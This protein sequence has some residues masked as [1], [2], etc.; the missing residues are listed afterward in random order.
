[1]A[2]RYN[3]VREYADT[4]AP[5]TVDDVATAPYWVLCAVRLNKPLSYSRDQKRSV[6]KDTSEGAQIRGITI[7]T[8][9][10]LQLQI[11]GS[12]GQHTKQLSATLLQTH[13]NYLI[14]LLPS[15]WLLAWIVHGEEK[16]RDLVERIKKLEPCNKWDDGL[17]FVGR[18]ESV[19]KAMDRNRETGAKSTR[20]SLTAYGFRE[21]DTAIF[22]DPFLRSVD[23]AQVGT[24]MAR[25]GLDIRQLFKNTS[26]Q[27]QQD[28]VHELIPALMEVFIGRGLPKEANTSQN[29]RLQQTTGGGIV[30]GGKPEEA[31]FAYLVPKEVGDLLGKKSRSKKGGIL[32]Y[33]D[34]LEL[35]FG[36]QKYNE[37]ENATDWKAFVPDIDA[38]SD[39]TT[40]SQRYTGVPMMGAFLPLMPNFD[41]RPMWSVLQQ[42]L[43]PVVNEMYTCLRVNE[44]GSVVPTVVLRQI[45]FTTPVL[46]AKLD[47]LAQ[48]GGNGGMPYTGFMDVP[49]WVLHPV[50]I[51]HMDI[52]RS[53][54]TRCNFVHVYGQNADVATNVGMSQ[55]LAQNP[56][57]RDD[58]DIQRSGLHTLMTTVACREVN[59]VGNVPSKWIELIAD[60][61]IGSQYT[62]NGSV[63][64]LGI[65][66]PI[67]EGDNLEFGNAVFHIESVAH[68]CSVETGTGRS[69]WSTTLTL[70]NGLRA[71][72]ARRNDPEVGGGSSSSTADQAGGDK[73]PLYPGLVNDDGT[74]L[75]PRTGVDDNHEN[76]KVDPAKKE[77]VMP[78]DPG[79]GENANNGTP[80]QRG[81]VEP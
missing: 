34:V 28:N 30:D 74:E 25:I 79:S 81:A 49:R 78:F 71:G 60:R 24:W 53:D 61:A 6:S 62:L 56:P 40:G 63:V 45:P 14:D 17:K 70:T 65:E 3:I 67:C 44:Q 38:D 51:E 23:T 64:T 35:L 36:V 41:N 2:G 11:Q 19:R 43:N 39:L 75:D 12:K 76:E 16:Q 9:D 13:T 37:H 46:A 59:K 77:E 69:A 22:Y 66:A 21:L 10:C 31:P 33:A 32:A 57:I 7:I 58:F 47:N 54:A 26:T 48:Y 68:T 8:S 50:L 15:D 52:G 5:E 73:F 20:Y 55:Q 80:G 1:M 27:G 72:T 4:D 29:P 42:Y 18:V